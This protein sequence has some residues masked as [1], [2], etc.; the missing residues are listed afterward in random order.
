MGGSS[1][2]VTRGDAIEFDPERMTVHDGLALIEE[3]RV[4]PLLK[5][6]KTGVFENKTNMTFMKAYTVVVQFGDQAHH[7]QMLYEYYKKVIR[8]YCEDSVS[9]MQ[10][11]VG[12]DLLKKL[13]NLWEK[14]T[15]LVYWMQRVFQYLDRF[16]TKNNNE[17]PDLFTAAMLSFKEAVYD[18][19]LKDQCIEALICAIN[20][21][22]DGYDIDQDVMR[23]LVEM[24]CTVGDPQP[25]IVKQKDNGTDRLMW[26]SLMKGVYRQHFEGLFLSR[27]AQ[28]YKSKVAGW[29][30]EHSCPVFLKEVQKRLD[31]E[32]SRLNRYLDRS[33]EQDLRAVCQ[34]ELILNTAEHL[35]GMD[36]GCQAMFLNQKYDELQLMYRLFK[37][38]ES[39]LPRMTACMKPYIEDRVS[40]ILED[41]ALID[42]HEEYI[43]KV[44]ALKAELDEMVAKCFENDSNFQKARNAVLENHL[45]KE[46]RCA[47]YLALFCDLQLKGRLKGRTEEET[48]QLVTQIVSL[49]AHLKD[50]D[51]FLESYKK[52]LSKR[53]LSR[54]SIS[55]DAEDSFISKLKVEC[56]QQAIQKLVA[57]FT[58]MSLSD[59]LQEEYSRQSHGASPGGVAHEVRVLQTNAWPEKADEAPIVPCAEMAECIKA[60]ESFYQSRHTGRKLRWIYNIGQQVEL[61]TL[62]YQKKHILA[63]SSYQALA[64]ML[65]NKRS[66]MTF[67]E[68]VDE[69]K[70]PRDECH[71]QVLSLTVSKHRLLVADTEEKKLE[72]STKLSVNSKFTNDKIKISVALIK[73]REKVEETKAVEAPVERKHVVDAAIVRIMKTRKRLDHNSLLVEVAK[74]CTLFRPQPPQIKVQIENLIDRAFLKRDE[75]RRDI[76]IYMP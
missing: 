61:T 21:E 71:R 47:H 9:L 35:V 10:G 39:T 58:D 46:T 41:Q 31:D 56:G 59:Q 38:E 63:L 48:T 2:P 13:A 73:E 27:T 20:K 33:A 22:R 57:M 43:T 3:E 8:E 19:V 64:L 66:E 69:T 60:F 28:Y 29:L 62:C 37:R 52:H 44:L 24:L 6:L 72:D 4:Q 25:S 53:L 34:R 16:F 11:L 55:S 50:K 5:Y 70:I 40:K 65:F 15:I 42:N 51:I 12:E 75:E 45:N 23:L 36:S 49:F 54:T 18:N 67:K 1:Q 17:F 7:S 26:N 76:Y 74:Q 32:D 14:N 68:I 30:A